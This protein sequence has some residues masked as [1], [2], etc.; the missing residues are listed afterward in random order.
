MTIGDTSTLIDS[1]VPT[2]IDSTISTKGTT[3]KSHT[4]GR[5]SVSS[6]PTVSPL[7]ISRSSRGTARSKRGKLRQKDTKRK[8]GKSLKSPKSL[9][10]HKAK[11][12]K[13]LMKNVQ[14]NTLKNYFKPKQTK[15]LPKK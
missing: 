1:E 12:K 6:L 3:N 4:S 5:M 9:K 14:K 10:A 13:P 11:R 7:S 15:G 2:L 8:K